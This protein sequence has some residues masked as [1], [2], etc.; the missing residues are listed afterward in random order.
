MEIKRQPLP[1]G[2]EIPKSH[3]IH[4]ACGLVEELI[5]SIGRLK[6]IYFGIEKITVRTVIFSRLTKIQE[7]LFAVIKSI[8]TT[9]KIEVKFA[10]SRFN[11]DRTA[12]LINATTSLNAQPFNGIPGNTIFEADVYSVWVLCKKVERTI[13]TTRDS[14]LGIIV[15]SSIRR[16]V[17]KLVEYFHKL[18]SIS[19]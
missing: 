4:V 5:G 6:A 17:S 1:C 10:A 14:K 7:D 19:L 18:I 12:E 3:K 9:P 13:L 11:R 2:E 16:Y 8:I 15:E